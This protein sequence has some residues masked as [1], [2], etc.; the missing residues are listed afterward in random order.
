VLNGLGQTAV[1]LLSKHAFPMKEQ[2]FL[3]IKLRLAPKNGDGGKDL[4]TP[5]DLPT[6]D[7]RR[8]SQGPNEQVFSDMYVYL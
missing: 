3:K 7:W 6:P 8:I 4:P 5:V 1:P 2:P